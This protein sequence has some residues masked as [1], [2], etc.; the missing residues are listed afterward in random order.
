M[1]A[2]AVPSP[3]LVAFVASGVEGELR[4]AQQLEER[5]EGPGPLGLPLSFYQ[6]P[7]LD[8][9]EGV[10]GYLRNLNKIHAL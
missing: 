9:R 1:P 7:I 4:Q 8:Y 2:P 3:V 10:K 5:P 6:S